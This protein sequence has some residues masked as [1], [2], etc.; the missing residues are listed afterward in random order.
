VP[1]VKTAKTILHLTPVISFSSV[2]SYDIAIIASHA[3]KLIPAGV[4]GFSCRYNLDGLLTYCQE[5]GV[6][7]FYAQL[8]R[9]GIIEAVEGQLL[10]PT[11]IGLYIPSFAF[12]ERLIQC[13]STY[14]SALKTLNVELP[15]FVFLTLVGVKGYRMGLNRKW[16]PRQGVDTIDRDIIEAPEVMVESYD[17]EPP[18]VLKPCFD[19]VW[20][21]CGFERSLN[22]TATGDWK[23]S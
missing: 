11:A 6:S 14:L 19:S 21:A 7:Q 22:Y 1:F 15:I 5:D 10:K 16:W 23:P 12:E 20:N 8:F 13:L 18:L 3:E 2:Q 4:G 9:N 17:V